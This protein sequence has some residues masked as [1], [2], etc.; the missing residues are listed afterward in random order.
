MQDN[1]TSTLRTGN[2]TIDIT[3]TGLDIFLTEEGQKNWIAMVK[4]P[5]MAMDIVEGLILVEAKRFYHP[6]A[7]PTVEINDS[8][9]KPP[10]LSKV[11]A[12][13]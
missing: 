4:D 5:Q 7:T 8:T 11:D 6:E 3:N 1:T 12:P 13:R 9:P 10:F 2:Y